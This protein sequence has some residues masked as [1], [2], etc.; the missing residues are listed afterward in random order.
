MP[1]RKSWAAVQRRGMTSA[2]SA[3]FNEAKTLRSWNFLN[4]VAQ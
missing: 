2:A 1:V 3:S 4:A